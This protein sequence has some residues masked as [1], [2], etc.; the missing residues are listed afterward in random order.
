MDINLS[1]NSLF[2]F[3]EKRADLIS[4]L[5]NGLYV[6]YSLENYQGLIEEK[7]EEEVNLPMVCFCDIPLSQVKRHITTYGSYAIG[8]T[9]KWGIKNKINPVIYTY[10]NSSIAN[11]L[12][13]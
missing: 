3:T 13:E 8:L 2:H 4:I 5:K 10:Y 1:A 9:K 11:I 7:E 6:R 12:D